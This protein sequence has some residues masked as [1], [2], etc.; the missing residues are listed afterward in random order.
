MQAV[1]IPTYDFTRHQRSDDSRRVEPADVIIIEGILVLHMQEVLPAPRMPRAALSLACCHCTLFEHASGH[2]C[3]GDACV[4]EGDY[5]RAAN[6]KL[7]VL[8]MCIG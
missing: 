6:F 5:A 8:Q 3:R 4:F 7:L 2:I 1:D